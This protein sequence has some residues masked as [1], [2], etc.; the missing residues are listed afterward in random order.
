MQGTSQLKLGI[1]DAV[2]YLKNGIR[3]AL[4]K[5]CRLY[6]ILPVLV[7]LIL[8]SSLG[9]YLFSNLK[10]LVFN[11][12]EDIPSY[13]NF[14]AYII[15]AILSITIIFVS[16]YIFST[17]ATIIASP[18]YGLLADKVEMILNQSHGEDMTI[19][20]LIK[21]IPRILLRELKKQMF[22]L[23]LA[24]ACLIISFIPALNLIAPVLWFALTA[25]MGCLQ[26][27]DY[28]YDNHKIPFNSMQRDLKKNPVATLSF[29]TVIALSL[30]VPVLNILIPP[31]AVCA[32]TRYYLEIQ[33][34]ILQNIRHNNQE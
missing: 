17:L 23:P 19:H 2:S 4:S 25:W 12:F 26:Y 29:G 21:D 3:L 28:A 20:Q 30:S 9:Y 1:M 33:K 27:C 6:I 16:C 31:A 7:N 11:I 18:F 32:G 22:F 15:S 34:N 24:L 5:E 10:T 8:L 14:L 13:L